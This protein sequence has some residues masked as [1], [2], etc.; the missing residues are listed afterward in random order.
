MVLNEVMASERDVSQVSVYRLNVNEKDLGKF[1]SSGI[2]IATGTGSTGWLY[3]A[4][5]ISA[6]Q[7][8]Q[9]KR[10]I[11]MKLPEDKSIDLIDYK[12]SRKISDRTVF[13]PE[14]EQMYYYVREGF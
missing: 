3:A 8:S 1:K 5:Q 6:G 9:L 2:I 14:R 13:P 10:L 4:K 12:I 11:G 7:V